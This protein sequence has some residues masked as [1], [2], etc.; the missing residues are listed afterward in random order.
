MV[1]FVYFKLFKSLNTQ[2][3][4]KI[5][6]SRGLLKKT[7][8]CIVSAVKSL[9]CRDD[10]DLSM[11]LIS[12]ESQIYNPT[13]CGN[14]HTSTSVNTC[15]TLSIYNNNNPTGLNNTKPNPLNDLYCRRHLEPDT[16]ACET[17]VHQ[18][19]GCLSNRMRN[20]A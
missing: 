2:I 5:L 12:N 20:G 1:F 10:L 14:N 16:I 19:V 8:N 7:D 18:V 15:S 6:L 9:T 11:D 17:A 4:L 13:F 3:L